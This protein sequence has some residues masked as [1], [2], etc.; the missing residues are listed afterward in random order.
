MPVGIY[1]GCWRWQYTLGC[2]NIVKYCVIPNNCISWTP[3]GNFDIINERIVFIEGVKR[4]I[5]HWNIFVFFLKKGRYACVPTIN[6]WG[7]HAK[8]NTNIHVGG[9][10]HL[11]RSSSS[12]L[13]YYTNY[14]THIWTIPWFRRDGSGSGSHSACHSC[15]FIASTLSVCWGKKGVELPVVLVV[16]NMELMLPT[17]SSE[18]AYNSFVWFAILWLTLGLIIISITNPLVCNKSLLRIFL[19]LQSWPVVCFVSDCVFV[20]VLQ[21][22]TFLY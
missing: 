4:S 3:L 6:K 10:F 18:F 7:L 12:S 21:D 20:A 5:K 11:Q 13:I 15:S 22:H 8:Y 9:W 16:S 2:D 19:C 14:K 17:V 1:P